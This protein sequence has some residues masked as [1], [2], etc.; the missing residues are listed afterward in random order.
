MGSAL[1]QAILAWGG[2]CALA[3]KTDDPARAHQDAIDKLSEQS[4][5]W[6]RLLEFLSK[7]RHDVKRCQEFSLLLPSMHVL[8]HWI[9]CD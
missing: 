7:M 8:A 9:W 2:I 1:R 6:T 5:C 4:W 3:E